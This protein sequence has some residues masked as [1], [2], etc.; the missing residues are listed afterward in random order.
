MK[1]LRLMNMNRSIVPARMHFFVR[2]CGGIMGADVSILACK[3]GICRCLEKLKPNIWTLVRESDSQKGVFSM[4]AH[5]LIGR[6]K[7]K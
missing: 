4:V 5:N 2:K 6:F 7:C 3:L 1:I